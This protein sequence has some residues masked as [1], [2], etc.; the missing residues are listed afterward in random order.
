MGIFI[1]YLSVNNLPFS[2][3]ENLQNAIG[4]TTINNV[5]KIGFAKIKSLKSKV[6]AVIGGN[7][8]SNFKNSFAVSGKM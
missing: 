3:L 4:G 7:G 2:V 8:I 6:A 1:K 5:S